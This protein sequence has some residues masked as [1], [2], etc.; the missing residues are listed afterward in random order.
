MSIH[1]VKTSTGKTI[2]TS[3]NPLNAWVRSIDDGKLYRTK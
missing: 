3:D 1:T 2:R